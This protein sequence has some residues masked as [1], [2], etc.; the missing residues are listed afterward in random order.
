MCSFWIVA[1]KSFGR[2]RRVG[3]W[4][5][6]VREACRVRSALFG[7]SFGEGVLGFVGAVVG[8]LWGCSGVRRS[9][10]FLRVFV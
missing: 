8:C 5:G 3:D 9:V 2:N 4:V 7:S 1:V 6:I 10:A